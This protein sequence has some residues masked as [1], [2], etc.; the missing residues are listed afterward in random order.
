MRALI[1]PVLAAVVIAGLAV[2]A[3]AALV[4]GVIPSAVGSNGFIGAGELF[5]GPTV[6]GYFGAQLYLVGGPANIQVDYWGAEAGFRNEFW[7]GGT[8]LFAHTTG[9]DTDTAVN[10]TQM[11]NAVPSGLLDFSFRI[12]N[13]GDSVFN[14][15]N[16]ENVLSFANFFV[17]F[18]PFS[19][20]PGGPGGGQTV[21][22][23][24]DDAG[25][26]P[27]DDHDDMLIQLS[28]TGGRLET[29]PEP[30]SMLLLGSGLAALW[31]RRRRS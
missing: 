12:P 22:I 25:A 27:D 28:V 10:G 20:A 4:A 9:D 19:A 29:V 30:G 26:G 7:W 17:T 15:S 8:Q 23:F 11:V 6:G 1:K 14:G 13:T 3:S 18:N 2:P 16:P 31:A 24:L 5:P 21:W